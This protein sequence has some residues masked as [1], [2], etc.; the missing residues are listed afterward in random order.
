VAFLRFWVIALL[1]Q[2][3]VFLAVR[4]MLRAAQVRRLQADWDGLHPA[5]SGNSAPR[6][7]FVAQ[8]MAGFDRTL[9]MRL[10]ILVFVLP[11]LAIWAIVITVNWQ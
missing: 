4:A 10:T 11:T 6:R 9:R 3:V 5:A 1:V 7:A 8:A 2:A